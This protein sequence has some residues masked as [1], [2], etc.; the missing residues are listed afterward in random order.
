MDNAK[1]LAKATVSTGYNAS[2]TS[3]VVNSGHGAKLPA[4][5]FRAAWWNATDYPDFSDD[6]NVEIVRVTAKSG[7]TLTVARAYEGPN[8]AS[9]K[10]TAGKTYV[11][12]AGFTAGDRQDI[13]DEIALKATDADLDALSAATAAALAAKADSDDLDALAAT[14]ASALALKANTSHAHGAADLTSGTIPDARFPAVL[15]AVSGENLTNLPGG[16]GITAL[17]GDVAASGAGSVAATIQNNAVSTAKINDGAVTTAKIG[18]SQVTLAKIQNVGA[19]KILGNLTGASGVLQE[20]QLGEDF[21]F[22]EGELR[23]IQQQ[24]FGVYNVKNNTVGNLAGDGVTDDTAALQAIITAVAAAGGGTIFFPDDGPYLI[25]GPLQ[26][27]GRQ[28]AQILLPVVAKEDQQ[29]TIR[30]QGYQV[31]ACSPSGVYS[32]DI[33]RGTVIKS[34]LASGTG[35]IIG[36]KGPVGGP[37]GEVNFLKVQFENLIFQTVANPTI[38]GLNLFSQ[39][40]VC[41]R[42]ILVVAGTKMSYDL[43]EPTNTGSYGIIMPRFSSGICQQMSGEVNIFG[44]YTGVKMGELTHAE[45]LGVWFCHFGLEFPFSYLA[46][47]IQKL[48]VFWTPYGA[49]WTDD[50]RVQ[51]IQWNVERAAPGFWYSPVYDIVDPDDHA[52]GEIVWATTVSEIGVSSVFDVDGGANLITRELGTANANAPT[53]SSAEVG[54]VSHSIVA[55]TFSQ[56]VKA[57]SYTAGIAIDVDGTPATINSA[58]RQ[59]DK[60]KVHFTLSTAVLT[61]EDVTFSYSA[62][63]GFYRNAAGVDLGNVTDAAVTNNIG[64]VTYLLEDTFTDTNGTALTSHTMDTGPGWTSLEGSASPVQIQSNKAQSQVTGAAAYQ[65]VAESGDADVLIECTFTLGAAGTAGGHYAQIIFRSVD[66]NNFWTLRLFNVASNNL[67]LVRVQGGV[68]NVEQ[69][70]T[71]SI[72]AD[73]PYLFSVTCIGDDIDCSVDATTLP[74]ETNSFNNTATKHGLRFYT[75]LSGPNTAENFRVSAA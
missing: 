54:L 62:I 3:I 28:N 16:S 13:I 70:A 22:T 2:A 5:P 38:S 49:R 6:P 66:V 71:F 53:F 33:P 31:P 67:Q 23:I 68:D 15:P 73:T 24:I 1:N 8:A 26:D 46:T 19:N 4:V 50:H 29:Y 18:D 32:I 48:L 40:S 74:T 69:Q 63:D 37:Y 39:T 43:S 56:T 57:S 72:A 64:G 36:G 17:T 7:D 55:V 21:T 14:T 9:A 59:S 61:G 45:N 11:L 42:E 35:A 41:L 60:T 44:F 27:T 25:D 47:L 30:F 65:Y 12:V 34:T 51:G 20:I 75:A 58:A 10:N 52:T